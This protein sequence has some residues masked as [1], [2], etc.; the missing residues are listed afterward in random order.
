M[1]AGPWSLLAVLFR[2]IPRFPPTRS[3]RECATPTSPGVC[4]HRESRRRRDSRHRAPPP[5]HAGTGNHVNGRQVF[6]AHPRRIEAVGPRA[7]SRPDRLG[8]TPPRAGIDVVQAVAHDVLAHHPIPRRHQQSRPA[9]IQSDPSGSQ[10]QDVA[11]RTGVRPIS[12]RVTTDLDAE[13]DRSR[14]GFR[15]ISARVSTDLDAEL[16]R[17]RRAGEIGVD[18]RSS[19]QHPARRFMRM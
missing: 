16:D 1:G 15:P 3:V 11:P 12:T 8:T 5:A 4:G 18:D 6:T 19:V 9:T 14:H 7:D 2:V 17:S 13:L 10:P